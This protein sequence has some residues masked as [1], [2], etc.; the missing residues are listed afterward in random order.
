MTDTVDSLFPAHLQHVMRLA[1]RALERAR[2]DG[3]VVYSGR[4]TE[5]FLDDHGPAFKANPHFL[6]WAPLQEAPDCFVRYSPGQRPQLVFHQPADYWH[7][8]PTVPT[9]AW[10]R[11]FDIAVIREPGEA[12]ALLGTDRQRLAFVGEAPAD[13]GGWGFAAINPDP[14]L[15]YLHYHRAAKTPY[16]LA[17]LREASRLGAIGHIAAAAAFRAGASEY[18]VHQAYCTAIGLRE[19]ELPYGNIIAFGEGA[20]ILH[21]TALGRSRD[22]P[23]PTFL[24][25]AG[26]Q[27]R[28]YASDITRTHVAAGADPTYLQLMASMEK[29]QLELCAAVKPGVDYRDIHLLAHR[30]IAGALV[31]AGVIKG[32]TA[33]DAATNGVSH[34]FFPH[35]IGHLLGLQVHD[36]AGLAADD[37][38]RTD[39]PRPAGH[40]YLRLTRKLEPGF[41]VTIEPGLYFIDLLLD[42]AQAKGLGRFINGE[43]VQRLKPY[44]G[45]RIED[46]VACTATATPENLTRDAFKR[47]A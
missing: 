42:E 18:E 14:L 26:G 27:Y 31:D 40:R 43:L 29:L 33:D 38:G 47:V 15:A 30:L 28:G 32:C 3:L 34:V 35:G 16:E 20:A 1:D 6:H 41:V 36:V 8:P 24:I 5:Y 19:Q 17:C 25:D 4:P 7:K 10:T 21:Y 13:I 2:C 39:I 9:A 11:E 23:R 44:G 45:I 22:V 37:T 46:D 12:R